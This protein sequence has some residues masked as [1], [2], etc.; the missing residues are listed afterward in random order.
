MFYVQ[1]GLGRQIRDSVQTGPSLT[2]SVIWM[3]FPQIGDLTTARKLRPY[4]AIQI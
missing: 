4:G 3:S 1:D 2:V